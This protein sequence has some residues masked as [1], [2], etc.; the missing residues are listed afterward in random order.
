MTM[1][2]PRCNRSRLDRFGELP[3]GDVLIAGD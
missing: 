3:E 1:L 2:E